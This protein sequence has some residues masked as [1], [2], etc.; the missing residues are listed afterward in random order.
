MGAG[1]GGGYASL[2]PSLLGN[3]QSVVNKYPYSSHSGLFGVKGNG[4]ARVIVSD[5][6]S[7]TAQAFFKDLSK[8]GSTSSV[9]KTD[10]KGMKMTKFIDGSSVTYRPN[11]KSG[12][13]SVNLLITSGSK[14]Q[15]YKIHFE[16][17]GWMPKK[18]KR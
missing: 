4:S 5:N 3:V 17:T 12:S 1:S 2:G 15:N 7:T 16:Q 9:A 14:Y 13:P 10:P 18:D 8:G 6:P 11:S